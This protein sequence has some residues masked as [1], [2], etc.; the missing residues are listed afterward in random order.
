MSNE[1]KKLLS[2]TNLKKYFPI[3]KT[4]FPARVTAET[5]LTCFT[6]LFSDMV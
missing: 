6:Y 3:A 2:V 5:R 1:K 4:A